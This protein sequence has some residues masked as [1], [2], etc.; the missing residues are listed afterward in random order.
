MLKPYLTVLL[1]CL[2][3]VACSTPK[4]PAAPKNVDGPVKAQLDPIAMKAV[5]KMT[6]RSSER[7]IE[8]HQLIWHTKYQ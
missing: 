7:V 4:P 6:P 2:S 3:L 5:A 1:A 8:P